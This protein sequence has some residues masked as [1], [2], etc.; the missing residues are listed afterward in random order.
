[1]SFVSHLE[2]PKCRS[3]YSDKD[4]NQLC[5]CGSPLL[6]RY[7]LE[8]VRS[9]ITK[10]KLKG[11]QPSM[12]RYLELLP[13]SD[14]KDVITLGEGFT[15]LLRTDRLAEQIGLKN[16]WLK[17]EGQ[18]PNGSFKSRGA[19]AGITKAKEL[20]IKAIAMPTAGNAGG[21]WSCYAAKAGIEAF[22]AMPKDA[23]E[24]TVKECIEAGAKAFLIDGLIGDAG[25]FIT[26][27]IQHLGL[28]DA[29]T[30]KEPYRVEGKKTMG[31]ELAEQFEWNL[32]DVILYP[33]GGGVGLIGMWKA[34]DELEELGWISNKRPKLVAVQSSGCA[35]IVKAYEEGK[36]VSEMWPDAHTFAGG[37]RVPK[38]LGDFLVLQAIKDTNGCAIAV[39]DDEILGAKKLIGSTEGLVICPEG[40]ALVAALQ[41]MLENNLIDINE[42]IVMFNTAAGIKYPELIEIASQPVYSP[43]DSSWINK[44]KN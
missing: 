21:A 15:P 1:M 3:A 18:N 39:S 34:F 16:L 24:I 7:H 2:C 9:A 40:A 22:I 10:D 25:T 4:I 29:S 36:G 6:V 33:C 41:K 19:S 20:G 8:K 31:F 5:K 12:W 26:K 38:A 42:R 27:G 23:P 37:L 44:Y 13:A 28:Y 32:P 14:L 43:D 11:R 35:P 30:L 17:D